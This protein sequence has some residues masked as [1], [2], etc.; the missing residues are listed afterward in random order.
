M[1]VCESITQCICEGR[2]QLC[3][4]DDFL[5]FLCV[6]RSIKLGLTHLHKSAL[7]SLEPESL[8]IIVRFAFII[9]FR[10]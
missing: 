3:G 8:T 2:G 5:T 7:V 1:C 10:N 4:V 6:L 9:A